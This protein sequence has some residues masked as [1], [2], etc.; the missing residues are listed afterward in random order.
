ME[1]RG[2]AP[3]FGSVVTD[4]IFDALNLTFSAVSQIVLVTNPHTL[5]LDYQTEEQGGMCKMVG[6]A[7][8]HYID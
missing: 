6:P 8:C 7:C 3:C 1:Q 4:V 5:V 2:A